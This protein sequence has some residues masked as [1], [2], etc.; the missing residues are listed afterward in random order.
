[1]RESQSGPR[2]IVRSD[3]ACVIGIAICTLLTLQ[4]KCGGYIHTWLLRGTGGREAASSRANL[5]WYMSVEH[6]QKFA[7]RRRVL[8]VKKKLYEVSKG[9]DNLT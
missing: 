6:L 3:V 7:L 1:M 5:N 2:V 9:K 4:G 8:E